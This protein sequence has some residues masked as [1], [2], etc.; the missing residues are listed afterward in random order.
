MFLEKVSSPNHRGSYSSCNSFEDTNRART[1]RLIY[2][3]VS[4]KAPLS[5][6]SCWLCYRMD[7]GISYLQENIRCDYSGTSGTHHPLMWHGIA[8][9]SWDIS[10]GTTSLASSKHLSSNWYFIFQLSQGRAYLLLCFVHSPLFLLY[11]QGTSPFQSFWQFSVS[12]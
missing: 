9:S 7:R 11:N 8:P 12:L 1:G 5:P 4:L 10:A 3:P 2:P 6:N